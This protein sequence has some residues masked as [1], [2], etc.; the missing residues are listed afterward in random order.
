MTRKSRK[1]LRELKQISKNNEPVFDFVYGKNEVCL[2]SDY[3]VENPYSFEWCKNDF[4]GIL[5]YLDEKQA[6]K[7]SENRHHF[8]ITHKGM[9]FLEIT[10]ES[11]IAFFVKSIFVPIGVAL[12]TSVIYNIFF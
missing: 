7:L 8:E 1:V 2:H 11:M 5:E 3:N 10:L 6:I 4:Y 9:N 12:L